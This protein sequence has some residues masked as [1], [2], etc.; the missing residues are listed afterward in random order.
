ML[1]TQKAYI[2][3]IIDGEGSVMLTRFH[4]NQLHSPCVTVASTDRD[5]LLWLLK[6][7][8]RGKILNK[9]NYNKSKHKN[10]YT[11]RV[12]YNDAI[13]LLCEVGPYLI[14]E[15]KKKRA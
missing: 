4:K 10:S 2:A 3:G 15:S 6:T 5:L 11:Y 14:I 12:I 13:S 1:D 8:G 9:K 7:V